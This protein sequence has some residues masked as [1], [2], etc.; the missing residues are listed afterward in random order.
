MTC[1]SRIFRCK[2]VSI[3]IPQSYQILFCAISSSSF[4]WHH[5][6]SWAASSFLLFISTMPVGL[7]FCIFKSKVLVFCRIL[8]FGFCLSNSVCDTYLAV[9]H[10]SVYSYPKMF[11]LFF[12]LLTSVECLEPGLKPS[13]SIHIFVSFCFLLLDLASCRTGTLSLTFLDFEILFFHF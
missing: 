10:S 7:C 8:Y 1:V 13:F 4:G 2:M 6:H 3:F 9:D 11:I 12:S 5:L